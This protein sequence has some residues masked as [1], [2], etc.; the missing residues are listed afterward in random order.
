MLVIPSSPVRANR[1][2]NRAAPSSMEYSVCTWRWTKSPREDESDEEP[3]DMGGE[4]SSA[5]RADRRQRCGGRGSVDLH[6]RR[7]PAGGRAPDYAIAAAILTG[8]TDSLVV[9]RVWAP[10]DRSGFEKHRWRSFPRLGLVRDELTKKGRRHGTE[11]GRDRDGRRG[12]DRRRTRSH[13]GARRGDQTGRWQGRGEGCGRGAR[14][15]GQ[16]RRDAE[17]GSRDR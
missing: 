7:E 10:A 5:A 11:E 15:P 13:E 16:D 12:L 9:R 1:S 14:V 3:D 4:D 6:R 2:S 8:H 17:A